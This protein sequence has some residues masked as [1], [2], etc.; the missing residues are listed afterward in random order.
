MKNGSKPSSEKIEAVKRSSSPRSKEAAKSFL[1]MTGYFPEFIPRYATLTAFSQ[2][3][4]IKRQS[5]NGV[6]RMKHLKSAHQA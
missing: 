4:T 6:K 3:L 1:D 2:E 5:S